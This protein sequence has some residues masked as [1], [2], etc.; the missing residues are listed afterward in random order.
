MIFFLISM[1]QL[2]LY[3]ACPPASCWTSDQGGAA[4][5]AVLLEAGFEWA[6]GAVIYFAWKKRR[7]P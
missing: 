4:F 2:W 3:L 7:K 1:H 6:L 5:S